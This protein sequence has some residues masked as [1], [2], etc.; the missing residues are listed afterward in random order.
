VAGTS[1]IDSEGVMNSG[2]EL[3]A[4]F[5]WRL[6]FGYRGLLKG[7]RGWPVHPIEVTAA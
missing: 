5:F 3:I 7:G 2:S 6:G 1:P 4:N